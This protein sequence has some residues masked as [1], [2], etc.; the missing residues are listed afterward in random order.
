MQIDENEVMVG[1][2][3]LRHPEQIRDFN[4]ISVTVMN[5]SSKSY[6]VRQSLSRPLHQLIVPASW[7]DEGVLAVRIYTHDTSD[8]CPAVE[9][10]H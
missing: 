7:Q 5:P 9:Q 10:A 3:Q 8:R 4:C 6:S 1:Y 2:D